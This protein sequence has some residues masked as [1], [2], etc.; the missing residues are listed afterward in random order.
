MDDGT[1]KIL[2]FLWMPEDVLEENG[3]RDKVP[4]QLWA[5]QG[6]LRTTPGRVL[7]YDFR[8]KE[9]IRYEH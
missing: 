3:K 9:D 6:Y 1:K 8:R 7:K 2:P 4:Y 5:K